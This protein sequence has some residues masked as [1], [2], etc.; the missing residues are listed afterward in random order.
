MKLLLLKTISLVM[1]IQLLVIISKLKK[2][3]LYLQTQLIPQV[4]ILVMQG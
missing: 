4:K 1:R 3:Q 2:A